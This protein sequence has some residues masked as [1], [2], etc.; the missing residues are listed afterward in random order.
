M[1][2]SNPHLPADSRSGGRSRDF[3]DLDYNESFLTAAATDSNRLA[4]FKRGIIEEP[5]I[6]HLA[7]DTLGRALDVIEGDNRVDSVMILAAG[8]GS[9]RGVSAEH[10]PPI[11]P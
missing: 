10:G 1:T 6:D 3:K 4:D 11:W 5:S 9:D 8:A 2:T 7:S